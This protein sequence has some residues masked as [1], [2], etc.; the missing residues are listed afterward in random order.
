MQARDEQQLKTKN[1]LKQVVL[2]VIDPANATLYGK[3][4]PAA[5]F[6]TPASG[7]RTVIN[8]VDNLVSDWR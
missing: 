3:D 4:L 2:G 5:P 6:E 7:T 1:T 8:L